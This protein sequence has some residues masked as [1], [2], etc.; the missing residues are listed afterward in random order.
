[1]VLGIG[2]GVVTGIGVSW[3]G[4]FGWLLGSG[5]G[6]FGFLGMETSTAIDVSMLAALPSI[7]WSI[8][9]WEKAKKRQSQDCRRVGGGLERGLKV[10]PV[11]IQ[12]PTCR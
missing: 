5:E 3:A 10:C 1:M 7:R 8:E 6:M 12:N 2:G 4:W 11:Y 9:I